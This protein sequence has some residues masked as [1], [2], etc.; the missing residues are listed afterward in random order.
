MVHHGFIIRQASV[1]MAGIEMLVVRTG[2][3]ARV[4]PTVEGGNTVNK[5]GFSLDSIKVLYCY[6][7]K[8]YRKSAGKKV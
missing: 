1:T 4:H 8:V 5:V 2:E 6:H 3:Q 7:V